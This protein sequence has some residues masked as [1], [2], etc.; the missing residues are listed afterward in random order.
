MIR[1]LLPLPVNLLSNMSIDQ[2]TVPI[3]ASASICSDWPSL[4]EEVHTKWGH[5]ILDKKYEGYVIEDEGAIVLACTKDLCILL[6]EKDREAQAVTF[7]DPGSS[8]VSLANYTIDIPPSA[9]IC[10]D[11]PSLEA[12]IKQRPGSRVVKKYGGFVI[13]EDNI[14]VFACDEKMSEEAGR[15]DGL[16][17]MLYDDLAGQAQLQLQDK[18]IA[19]A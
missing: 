15:S 17:D 13:E 14:I 10:S 16:V 1:P 6:E 11:W 9:K 18:V 8:E 3:P 4:I 2:Y 5:C 19:L 7:H 12:A